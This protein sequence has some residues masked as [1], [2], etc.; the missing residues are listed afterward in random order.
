MPRLDGGRGD[1]VVH[2][3]VVVP[4]RLTKRQRELLEQLGESF[5][6]GKGDRRT[7]LEKLKDWL[8]G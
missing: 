1:F 7:P 6:T 2:L 4:K 3:D 8:G 5:G